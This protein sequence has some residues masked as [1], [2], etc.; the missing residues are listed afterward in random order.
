[1]AARLAESSCLNEGGRLSDVPWICER[2]DSMISLWSLVSVHTAL[3][4]ILVVGVP[5]YLAVTAIGRRYGW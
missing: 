2:A 5:M 4:S 3:L 1:M